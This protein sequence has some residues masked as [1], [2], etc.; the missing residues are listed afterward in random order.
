MMSFYAQAIILGGETVIGHH[1]VI[2]GNVW[3]T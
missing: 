3:L 2:G 1:S